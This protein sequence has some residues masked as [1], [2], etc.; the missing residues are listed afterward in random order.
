MKA[1]QITTE[2]AGSTKL[3]SGDGCAEDGSFVLRE[4]HLSVQNFTG[5]MIFDGAHALVANLSWPLSNAHHFDEGVAMAIMT[6]CNSGSLLD[7]GAGSGQY[8]AY[9]HWRRQQPR[10]LASFVDSYY[11][12]DG[13][14]GI[15]THLSE[16]Y[17]RHMPAPGAREIVLG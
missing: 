8:G 7:V 4:R 1:Q 2:T 15:E 5:R 14:R 17:P 12:V 3:Q 6:A 16:A 11:G 9:F 13:L 10:P